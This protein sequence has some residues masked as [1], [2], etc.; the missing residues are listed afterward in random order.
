MANS[1]RIYLIQGN[2]TDMSVCLRKGGDTPLPYDLTGASRIGL[3]LTGHGL[4]FFARDI[5]VSGED[6]NII[7]G[8]LAG[9]LLVGEYGLEV[10]F[11]LDGKAKRFR[12]PQVFEVVT[13]LSEDQDGTAEGEGD[14]ISI[15][16]TVQPESIEIAGPTGPQ[17]PQGPQGET[18]PTGPQGLKGDKG[19]KGDTGDKGDKGATGAQGPKGDTGEQ[20]PQGIQGEKGEKGDKGDK[21]DTGAQGPQGIQ[22]PQGPAGSDADVT[23]QNI[24]A[25]LGYTPADEDDLAGKED[26]SNKVKSISSSSTDMQYP[27]AKAVRELVIDALDEG[28]SDTLLELYYPL[29]TLT[30]EY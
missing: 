11:T 8:L 2:D 20:G 25:A 4:S 21:G 27:S 12:V 18:G 16:V 3:A 5:E 7:S 24:E 9:D 22:G 23:R 15:T 28:D 6:N 17:G 19:D 13:Y 10:S 26:I 14:G 29:D 30:N 1:E